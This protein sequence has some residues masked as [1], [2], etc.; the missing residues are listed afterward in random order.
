V[1]CADVETVLRRGRGAYKYL[2]GMLYALDKLTAVT[3]IKVKSE[4]AVGIEVTTSEVVQL[5][6]RSLRKGQSLLL[7]C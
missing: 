2:E 3:R 4:S 1:Q 5:K 7:K 6:R